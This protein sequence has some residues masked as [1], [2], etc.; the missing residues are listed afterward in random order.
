M[1]TDTD[2]VGDFTAGAATEDVIRL[3]DYGP[4]FDTFAEVMAVATQVSTRV[5]IDFGGGDELHLLNTNIG[6]LHPDDFVFAKWSLQ[7]AYITV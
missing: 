3:L 5:V 6:D 2:Y 4:A 7:Q 1:D